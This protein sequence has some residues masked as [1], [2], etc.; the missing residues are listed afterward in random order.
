MKERV[1]DREYEKRGRERKI[2]REGII[3]G[4][5]ESRVVTRKRHTHSVGKIV[6]GR[7][8]GSHLTDF[9]DFKFQAFDFS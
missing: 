2:A 7:Y 6:I 1:T 3:E 8:R 9:W 4:D 5:G